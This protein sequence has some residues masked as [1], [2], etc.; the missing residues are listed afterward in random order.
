MPIKVE[1]L[2]LQ[3]GEDFKPITNKNGEPTYGP[4]LGCHGLLQSVNGVELDL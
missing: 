2:P 1:D 4:L 3:L